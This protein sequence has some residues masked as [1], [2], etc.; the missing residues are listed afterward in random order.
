M[1]NLISQGFSPKLNSQNPQKHDLEI[2]TLWSCTIWRFITFGKWIFYEHVNAPSS[3]PW[4]YIFKIVQTYLIKHDLIPQNSPFDH[5]ES[6][7]QL[8]S[9]SF[10]PLSERYLSENIFFFLIWMHYI[11]IHMRPCNYLK[12]IWFRHVLIISTFWITFQVI[13]KV[14]F[15]SLYLYPL[16]PHTSHIWCKRVVIAN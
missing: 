2:G 14:G 13:L 7:L 15:F 9:Q 5:L 10:K 3:S 11:I 6:F 8:F 12:I 4:K 16:L 1:E